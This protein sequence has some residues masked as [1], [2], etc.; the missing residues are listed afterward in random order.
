MLKKTALVLS[1]WVLGIAA[2]FAAEGDVQEQIVQEVG[3]PAIHIDSTQLGLDD[4]KT[5][6][7]VSLVKLSEKDYK[8]T[9]LGKTSDPGYSQFLYCA[10]RKVALERGFDYWLLLP[11][12]SPNV[13]YVGYLAA[14]TDAKHVTAMSRNSLAIHSAHQPASKVEACRRAEPPQAH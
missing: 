11:G 6:R 7:Q 13:A 9:D 12:R 4:G 14:A 2:A 5:I 3:P 8:I 1:A 10:L